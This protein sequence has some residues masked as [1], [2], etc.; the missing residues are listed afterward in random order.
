[1]T[2]ITRENHVFL[3]ISLFNTLFFFVFLFFKPGQAALV[4]VSVQVWKSDLTVVESL[5]PASSICLYSTNHSFEQS[6]VS[7]EAG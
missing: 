6:A 7:F 4:N 2:S 1:M 5:W 3:V